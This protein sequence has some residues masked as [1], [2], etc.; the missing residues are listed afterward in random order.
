MVTCSF[1]IKGCHTDAGVV[2]HA[3]L[4]LYLNVDRKVLF[5]VVYEHLRNNISGISL[6]DP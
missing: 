3:L 5:G 1:F 6:T 4:A 2:V